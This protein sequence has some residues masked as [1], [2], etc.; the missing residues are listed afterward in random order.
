[1]LKHNRLDEDWNN[2]LSF[3][4]FHIATHDILANFTPDINTNRF[5]ASVFLLIVKLN[6]IHRKTLNIIFVS[7]SLGYVRN[8]V[9]CIDHHTL[10]IKPMNFVSNYRW[11]IKFIRMTINFFL[12]RRLSLIYVQ[13]FLVWFFMYI[14]LPFF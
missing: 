9:V 11:P 7:L 8:F 14:I 12:Q 13:L 1:M 5:G 10:E 2:V 3:F 4:M 6:H